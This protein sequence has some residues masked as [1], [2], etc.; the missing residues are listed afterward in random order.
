MHVRGFDTLSDLP[1]PAGSG[2]R[3]AGCARAPCA[4]GRGEGWRPRGSAGL[5]LP[6]AAADALDDLTVAG[7]GGSTYSTEKMS[8]CAQEFIVLFD[9]SV[10]SLF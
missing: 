4:L 3:R 10:A 5:P 2:V 6:L 9:V 7:A 1:A 8:W